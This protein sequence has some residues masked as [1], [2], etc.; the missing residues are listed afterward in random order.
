MSKKKK[1][2]DDY[3]DLGS[4]N[5]Y[6]SVSN[7]DFAA[8]VTANTDYTAEIA[9]DYNF[10]EINE[11]VDKYSFESIDE[12]ENTPVIDNDIQV[13]T[14]DVDNDKN[15]DYLEIVVP[16]LAKIG[17]NKVVVDYQGYGLTVD[18][19][20]TTTKFVTLKVRGEIGTPDFN[21]EVV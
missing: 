12:L 4:Y 14:E 20:D 6:N 13:Y 10:T 17:K 1:S 8:D 9:S 15:T 2:Y 3:N 16:V 19:D 11:S 18:L 7:S 21:F 5:E